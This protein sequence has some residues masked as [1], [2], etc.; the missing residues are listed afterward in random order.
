MACKRSSVRLRY[1]PLII[2]HLRN[3]VG[4]FFFEAFSLNIPQNILKL[5][6]MV[7]ALEW[8]N[9]NNA[10]DYTF[11]LRHFSKTVIISASFMGL[12]K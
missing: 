8:A 7:W 11:F 1:S 5:T 4:A 9:G 3:H 2:R 12:L 10:W 6:A